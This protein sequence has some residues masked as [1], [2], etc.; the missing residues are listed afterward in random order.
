MLPLAPLNARVLDKHG[1]TPFVFQPVGANVQPWGGMMVFRQI[2]RESIRRCFVPTTFAAAIGC[3]TPTPS[4]AAP[5]PPAPM[6]D[7]PD[8]HSHIALTT[9]LEN[10]LQV[11]SGACVNDDLYKG[12]IYVLKGVFKDQKVQVSAVP[13][14]IRNTLLTSFTSPVYLITMPNMS[15]T[16]EFGYIYKDTER[17]AKDDPA[18]GPMANFVDG[19]DYSSTNDQMVAPGMNANTYSTSCSTVFSSDVDVTGAYVLPVSAIKGGMDAAYSTSTSYGLNIVAGRFE[20]PLVDTLLNNGGTK[21]IS[22]S[23]RSTLAFQ[24]WDWYAANPDRIAG[25]NWL[26]WYFDGVALYRQTSLKQQTNFNANLS[27]SAGIPGLITISTSDSLALTQTTTGSAQAFEVANYSLAD[28]TASRDYRQLPSPTDLANIIAQAASAGLDPTN[29]G[30]RIIFNA[31]TPLNFNVDIYGVPDKDC[32][33]QTWS[34]SKQGVSI[35]SQMPQVD[36]NKAHYCAIGMTYTPSM[37]DYTNGLTI[38]GTIDTAQLPVSHDVAHIRLAPVSFTP[39][40]NPQLLLQGSGAP[41]AFAPPAAGVMPVTLNWDMTL[42][43]TY[44]AGNPVADAG[45]IGLRGL[46]VDC[47][48]TKFYPTIGGF[49]LSQAAGNTRSLTVPLS[50]IFQSDASALAKPGT[51]KVCNIS[52]P[53][54]YT[55]S[56]GIVTRSLPL[57]PILFPAGTSG[58]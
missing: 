46:Y 58:S 14:F 13:R 35:N 50:Y 17:A 5:P 6:A 25:P 42:Q 9:W 2:Y 54:T 11:M 44:D 32:L 27:A 4:R 20:S 30:D 3:I 28:G 22:P 39:T 26:L 12:T 41:V 56:T 51:V 40:S 24:L 8:A 15:V 53:V 34:F 16:R 1:I 29:P 38:S 21:L 33:S 23:T 36:S 37:G 48:T 18:P 49:S 19:I 52:G 31:G 47:G 55:L 43:L 57:V 10:R 7:P 45:S